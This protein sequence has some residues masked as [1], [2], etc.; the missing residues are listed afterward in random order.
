MKRTLGAVG[1]VALSSASLRLRD[2]RPAPADARTVYVTVTDKA[3]TPVEDL[4]AAD[5]EIKEGGKTVDIAEAGIAKNPLQIALIVDDNGT[6][7]FRS[8]LTRF[9]QRM[10]G[11][12]VM[13][14][15]LGHRPDDEAGRLHAER[16]G[17]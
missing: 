1:A 9:V 2:L 14:L 13:A 10:D 4:T 11:H 8:P 17:D 5:F 3:G 15:Q 12:A 7:L 16:R 6:G